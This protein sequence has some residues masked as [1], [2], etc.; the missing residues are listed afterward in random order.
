MRSSR[1]VIARKG[2]RILPERSRL[3]VPRV[4]ADLRRSREVLTDIQGQL[5]GLLLKL[6]QPQPSIDP[7]SPD[8]LE[9]SLAQAGQA[10]A[11]I[12]NLRRL[13]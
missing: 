13:W 4:V 8:R 10:L 9:G 1:R 12:D 7:S 3:T 6:R 11:A 5:D 2:R